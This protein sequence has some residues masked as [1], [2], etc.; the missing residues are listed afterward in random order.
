MKFSVK[1]PKPEVT[2]QLDRQKMTQLGINATEVGQALQNAFRGNTQSKY[3]QE[4]NEYD[5]LVQLDQYDR[6]RPE[7]CVNSPLLTTTA[8]TSNSR[9]LPT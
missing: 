1:D 3:K 2:V 5:I 4:G 9:S 8:T 7:T 6:S